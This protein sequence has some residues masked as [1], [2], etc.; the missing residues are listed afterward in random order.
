MSIVL[1]ASA[2]VATGIAVRLLRR[3]PRLAFAATLLGAGSISALLAAAPSQSGYFLG[4]P[5]ALEPGAR[6]WLGSALGA[7][8]ALALFA[9]L[10]FERA[11]N[12]PAS[13]VANSQGAFFFW[14]LAAFVI[15][16]GIGSFP[17]A[18]FAW[19]IGLIV[20]MLAAQPQ[21]EGRVGGAGQFLL[22]IVIASAC[23]LLAHRF[24]EMY[25]LT[26]ENLE[27]PR[28]AAI[29][30]ALGFGLLLAAA[31]LHIWLGPLA[32]ESSPLG[33]AFLV[34][35]AQSVGAWLLLQQMS[36]VNWLVTRSPWLGV[37]MWGGTL[38]APLGAGLALSERRDARGLAYLSLIPLGHALIGLGLGTRLALAGALLALTNR[39]W[40][41]ALV[42]GGMILARHHPERRWQRVSAGAI[43]LGGMALAGIP[44]L[45]GFAA[46]YSIY[47]D[48][49]SVNPTLLAVLL[50]SNALAVLAVLRMVWRIV[51]EPVETNEPS[52]E[53]KVIPYFCVV[54]A[55]ALLAV[56]TG[57]GISPQFL[58]DPMMESLGA[59][60]YLK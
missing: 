16:I 15:A 43:L 31:P 6:V 19:A 13:A 40:G 33:I 57:A 59:A 35:V 22:L 11:S 36:D 46:N 26:P 20:L 29:F 55:L 12:A 27:L 2:C 48:L 37:L 56:L 50:G 44:P 5:L 51:A 21:N 39:A 54:V 52:Q 34:G 4:R 7:A 32:D 58:T 60:S 42:A 24:F 23:L 30:L 17:L 41:G 45:L 14:A 9:P 10:T 25:P 38:T 18:V 1:I 3:L 53:V 47:R 8:S 28:D 49:G